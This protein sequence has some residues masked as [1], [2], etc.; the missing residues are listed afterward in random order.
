[1]INIL[2]GFIDAPGNYFTEMI[3]VANMWTH[4]MCRTILDRF[5]DAKLK[6]EIHKAIRQVA[7]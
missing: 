2:V 5:T 3:N 1:M 6:R 4:E 7:I